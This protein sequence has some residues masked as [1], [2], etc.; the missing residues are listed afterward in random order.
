M[1]KKIIWKKSLAFCLT[2][3]LLM[4]VLSGC[5]FEKEEQQSEALIALESA[6]NYYKTQN[7]LNNWEELVALCAANQADGIGIGW[8]FLNL[9]KTP[10]V[11]EYA[12]SYIGV[13]LSDTIKGEGDPIS[14]AKKLSETQNEESGSFD[15][16][17]INQHVWAMITLNVAISKDG[18]DY[19]K[20][21]SY[22]L[23]YQAEDGG[24]AYGQNL[25]E[26]NVDLTGIACIALA[27]YYQKH[28]KDPAMKKIIQ[29]FKDKQL[30]TGGFEN[31]DVENPCTIAAAI[32]GLSAFEQSL[33]ST[34]EGLTPFEA[35]VA[36]QNEDG[37]FRM[38]KDG[39]HKF[40]NLA[41]RQSTIALC[42][43]VND[44]NTYL[45][46]ASGAETYRIDHISGPAITLTIDYPEGSGEQ[47][48]HGPFTIE[49]GSTV[50]DAIVLY[51]KIT[52]TPIEHKSGDIKSIN[53]FS[54][55]SNEDTET[56][57]N[58]PE[59]P[60]GWSFTVN[61]QMPENNA[62]NT[63]LKEGDLLTW[64]F[65]PSLPLEVQ[66]ENAAVQ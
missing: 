58:L 14:L 15:S 63:I 34:D 46:L 66:K 44:I 7:N 64:T 56:P 28:K 5:S 57:N 25:A 13:I 19:D 20:A 11:N 45:L 55:E 40:D 41:T 54:E 22:L 1:R 37:S 10:K 29:F 16:I 53:G 43:I 52:E 47:D 59:N 48:V 9:P 26:G 23:S 6:V 62:K 24:F 38:K 2:F 33:P 36:F 3:C 49:E 32:W 60:V 42:D 50:L 21:V 18:Y 4:S 51:G 27:P 8:S 65:A 61:N 17:Y 35:L 30:E 12:S 31:G 39:D